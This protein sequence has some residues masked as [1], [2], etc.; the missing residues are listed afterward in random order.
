[1]A[2]PAYMWLTDEQGQL[3]Q[4]DCTVL[5]REHSVELLG[6]KHHVY[7]PTDKDTGNAMGTRK[8]EPLIVLVEYSSLSPEIFNACTNGKSLQEATI[9]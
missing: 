5:G 9:R 7:I 1:M 3:L 2:N 8:H 4:G 6:F